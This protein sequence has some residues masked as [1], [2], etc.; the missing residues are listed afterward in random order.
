MIAGGK[1]YLISRI[2][3]ETKQAA[4]AE[5]EPEPQGPRADGS[6]AAKLAL[7]METI[8]KAQAEMVELTRKTVE[9]F[10]ALADK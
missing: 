2:G 3:N 8:A 10:Q 1:N 5:S 9:V 7:A 6:P 4:P